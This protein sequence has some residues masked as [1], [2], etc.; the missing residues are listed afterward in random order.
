M[1][2]AL[3]GRRLKNHLNQRRTLVRANI[4]FAA[5]IG[6]R[7]LTRAQTCSLE[8]LTLEFGLSVAAGELLLMDGGWYV[9]HTG[10]IRLSRR[11]RCFGITVQPV[12]AFCDPPTG[13]YGFR[14]TVYK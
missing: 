11:E 2:G 5:K 12:N 13:R 1:E 8:L 14:A 9:T 10:L 3:S 6:C 7:N 4:R